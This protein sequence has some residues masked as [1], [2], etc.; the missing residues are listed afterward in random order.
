MSISR[1]LFLERI[2]D[3]ER[4]W[5][6]L[7]PAP[8]PSLSYKIAC[9]AVSFFAS[10]SF[11]MSLYSLLI[12]RR[13]AYTWIASSIAGVATRVH[14]MIRQFKVE[15][16]YLN[17][18]L[19]IA[20]RM[21]RIE[22]AAFSEIFKKFSL[23]IKID[24]KDLTD[25]PEEVLKR[26]F[27]KDLPL[28]TKIFAS[29]KSNEKHTETG[30][31]AGGL[32][33][34]FLYQLM[35][36]LIGKKVRK[37]ALKFEELSTGLYC[38]VL[39]ASNEEKEESLIALG[40]MLGICFRNT[41]LQI[42]QVF[43]KNFYQGL[44]AFSEKDLKAGKFEELSFERQSEIFMETAETH[45]SYGPIIKK[46]QN[47]DM[48]SE[49]LDDYI[50]DNPQLRAT[51]LLAK[52]IQISLETKTL[53]GLWDKVRKKEISFLS[54]KI[55][56]PLVTAKLLQS[57]LVEVDALGKVQKTQSKTARY[58]KKWIEKASEASLNKFVTAAYGSPSLGCKD[59]RF[60]VQRQ[61]D[62]S[63]YP[64]FHTCI[65]SI[66]IPQYK[67]YKTFKSQVE[68]GTSLALKSGF[69]VL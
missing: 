14:L 25:K 24:R 48:G 42:G 61:W 58:F 49:V 40:R 33:R 63:Y 62:D 43:H 53:V 39:S 52:G 59:F 23:A 6:A 69:H 7:G 1:D 22:R 35:I 65:P 68:K 21:T 15:K 12:E 26:Y 28:V 46:I 37:N 20:I 60:S 57:L 50:N 18:V 27:R 56:G 55:Q 19:G 45:P 47:G 16:Q 30:Q 13:F 9:Y 17:S 51:F 36:G 41:K 44:M 2:E 38:P 32:S 29:F 11:T 10:I 64:E 67:N 5:N 31:D 4:D 34:D 3:I 66:H 8:K 54:K